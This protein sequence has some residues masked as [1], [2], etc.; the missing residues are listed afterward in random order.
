ML[1]PLAYA[2]VVARIGNE[3]NVIDVDLEDVIPRHVVMTVSVSASTTDGQPL[4]PAELARV[5]EAC[6]MMQELD[7]ARGA[8]TRFV[9]SRMGLV[10]P[11]LSAVCGAEVAAKLVG[12]AGGLARLSEI[13]AVQH[14]SAGPTEAHQRGS[15]QSQ[16]WREPGVC[17]WLPTRDE[18]SARL[19]PQGGQ[20]SGQ[21][22][23]A[24]GA[25]RCV[26]HE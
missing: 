4:P 14:T 6:A 12:V 24:V 9:G 23:G 17:L 13:P 20:A 25:V 16:R 15:V 22:G 11:N 2:R 10:A 19:P 18:H 7:A 26:R 3:E 21:Q 5:H 8:L 1:D